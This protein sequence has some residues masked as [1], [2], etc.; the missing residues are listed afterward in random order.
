[1]SR[2]PASREDLTRLR[3]RV[4]AEV[5]AALQRA[6]DLGFLGRM[7]LGDQIDHALGFVQAVE[8]EWPAGP[9]SCLDLG[10]G[11]GVPGLV[12]GSCWS[13]CHLVLVDASQRRTDFLLRELAGLP[14]LG[15]IRV[16]RGRAE[17]LARD[18]LLRERFEA[19][20]SRSF[21]RPGTTAECGSPFLLRGGLMVV[22]E[23]PDG[24]SRERW[25]SSGL[26]RLGLE[27]AGRARFDRRFGYQLLR[28]VSTTP[29][30]YPRRT[31]VPTK[32][33]LF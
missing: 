29:D 6:A 4:P 30:P 5:A 10:T 11:G 16:V 26:A 17:V 27:E 32:R 20:T 14:R 9:A 2:M 22:S 25:P 21:G 13:D 1:V 7:E 33:P 18:P 19:A 23:P 8:R 15:A 24:L 31:G 3:A 12:L 28:K